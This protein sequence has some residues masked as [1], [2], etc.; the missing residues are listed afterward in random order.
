MTS[1]RRSA[2]WPAR[3]MS[4]RLRS[5]PWVWADDQLPA[6][7]AW[8]IEV[9]PAMGLRGLR[10]SLRHT[11]LLETQIRAIRRASRE[12]TVRIMSPM[13]LGEE[14]LISALEMIRRA[15]EQEALER[16]PPVGAMI[17]T[18]TAVFQ[19]ETILQHVDLSVSAPTT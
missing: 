6:L 17:E 12:G 9:N 2:G 1:G 4:V 15:A 13:V 5:A 16:I 11:E 8:E 14:D 19:I 7:V 10:Y 3:S 18:P